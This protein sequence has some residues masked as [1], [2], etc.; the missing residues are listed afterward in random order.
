MIGEGA[1]VAGVR[2]YRYAGEPAQPGDQLWIP[3]TGLGAGTDPGSL[4]VSIGDSTV[5]VEAVRALRTSAGVAEVRITVPAAPA[6]GEA[7][8]L[9]IQIVLPDGRLVTS[10][11]VTIAIEPVR[12]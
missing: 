4:M 8:P 12:P 3:V 7:V 6:L 11:P 10:Q 1:L 9:T 2:N 5:S